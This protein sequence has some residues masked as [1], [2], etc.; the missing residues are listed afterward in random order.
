MNYQ[1]TLDFL[2]TQVPMFQSIGAGAYKPGLDTVRALSAKFGNPHLR[3]RTIHVGG[4]NG[5]GSTAHTLAAVLQSAGYKTGL[6][7]SPHLTDFRERIRID[8]RMISREAVVDFVGRYL[9]NGGNELKPSFFELTTIMAFEYFEKSNVDVAVIEVG[10]GGRLDSTNIITPDLSVITNISLDHTALLGHTPEAIATEKAGIIKEGVPVVIGESGGAVREVF[11]DTAARR[12]A[13]ICYADDLIGYEHAELHDDHISYH[14]TLYGDLTGELCGDCQLKNASTILCSIDSL[15]QLGYNIS[16]EAVA[17]GFSNVCRLTGLAG[18]WMKVRENPTVI[19]DT[20]H[21]V[22]GW[23][24]L[25]ERLSAYGDRLHMVIGF[26]NDK[27]VSGILKMMPDKAR[28]YF[29]RPSVER[30]LDH[31]ALAAA[32]SAAGKTGLTFGSVRD[33][34]ENALSQA[35][36]GDI[37]FVGGST[38]V[39]ADLMALI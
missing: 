26:V 27:D 11:A 39:V 13:P 34:Y 32:A 10:L 18:R 37:V 23:S 5:K 4:T 24:Y 16:S 28:Y 38:F 15:C 22:G 12:H 21:N 2:Y 9:S 35:K 36:E 7:T 31:N 8:G 20:G 25:A 1:E 33:G 30:G 29:V 6:F 19:C 17:A 14:A 3:L